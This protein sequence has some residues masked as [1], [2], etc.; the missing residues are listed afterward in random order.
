MSLSP[1]LSAVE[2]APNVVMYQEIDYSVKSE[3]EGLSDSS[4][5]FR[6]F[7]SVHELA[8]G[9]LQQAQTQPPTQPHTISLFLTQELK[10][11]SLQV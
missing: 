7:P 2:D 8:M 4:G 5:G 9:Y 11:L 10:A 1:A 3:K 6:A